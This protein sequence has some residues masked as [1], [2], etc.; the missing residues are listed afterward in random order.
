MIFLKP[1]N[2]VQIIYQLIINSIFRLRTSIKKRLNL[3]IQNKLFISGEF[4]ESLST[5]K[6]IFSTLNNFPKKKNF[7]KYKKKIWIFH[8]SDET[9]DLKKKK[10]LD[11]FMPKKC[12]SQN[13]VFNKKNY[14]FLPIGLENNKFHNNGDTDDFNKLRKLNYEKKPRILFGFNITNT[15]RVQIKKNLKEADITDETKGWNAYLYRRIL[16]KYMFVVCPEGNGID[17]HR[18]WEAFYL[19]TIPIMTEN[20][21]SFFLKKANLPVLILKR[22]SDILKFNENNL[23]R[24]YLSKKKLFSNK[25]LFQAYWKK[26]L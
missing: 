7:N 1:N 25:Y 24:L 17:T 19:R 3:Q 16:L 2:I 21:I 4:F 10:K 12:F 23:K 8:N 11:Y 22:W 9:F 18:I 20:K 6:V 15:K 26:I 13:L 5:S 14:Y